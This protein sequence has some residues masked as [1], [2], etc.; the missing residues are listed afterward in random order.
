MGLSKCFGLS[1]C[2]LTKSDQS[3][4]ICQTR[5]ISHDSVSVLLSALIWLFKLN[6]KMFSCNI[7][8]LQKYTVK[9]IVIT[10]L[11]FL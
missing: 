6:V 1:N 11:E 7:F 10:V 5:K 9:W 3:P 4:S 8:G 2:L